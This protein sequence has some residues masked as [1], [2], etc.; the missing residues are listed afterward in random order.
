MP[1][2]LAWS[3]VL[4]AALGDLYAA[5]AAKDVDRIVQPLLDNEELVGLI[6]GIVD[7]DRRIVRS[8][9]RIDE[10]SAEPP[11]EKTI[12]E[13][14]SVTKTFTGLLLADFVR[15]GR[16][17][18]EDPVALY[19]PEDVGP[20]RSGGRDVRLV[21]LATHAS[22]LPRLPSNLQ[23]KDPRDPYADYDEERL[24]DFLRGRSRWGVLV[25]AVELFQ[26][27]P[28]MRSTERG[29]YSYSNLAVGLLGHVLARM[30]GSTYESLLR[31]VVAEPLRLMD[32]RCE[33]DE[34]R[35]ARLAPGYADGEPVANWGFGCLAGAGAAR[36]TLH[37]LVEYARAQFDGET[38]PL[39]DA[40]R[41]T[42]QPL[43]DAS[44]ETSIA[45]GWHVLK[46]SQWIAHDGMTGG[47]AASVYVDPRGRRGVVVLGNQATAQIAR[48]GLAL[49]R[50]CVGREVQ[51]I[52]TKP[53]VAVPEDELRA[54]EGAYEIAGGARFTLRVHNGRLRARLAG[55]P[56]FR[57][58]AESRDRFFYRVVDATVVFER[59]PVGRVRGLTLLQGGRKIPAKRLDPPAAPP[60]PEG[61]ADA[62]AD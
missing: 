55:Q 30:D 51:P 52:P 44:S 27:N 53:T 3:A 9:G 10:D 38:G 31:T 4:A 56:E 47:Y 58:Y 11:D 16:C 25:G 29:K 28:A 34:S 60:A 48:I 61:E 8:Y 14:G 23:P 20:V 41:M 54:Y 5:P 24:F 40:V 13:I 46:E 50:F 42:H 35:R 36:S 45:L 18:L 7:G 2:A 17:R 6:V 57:L 26:P 12:F 33:L 22:G 37:D 59:D 62:S 1:T 32:T 39:S 15:R 49:H 19:L 21:D 43:L